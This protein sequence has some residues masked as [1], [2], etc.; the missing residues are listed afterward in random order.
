MPETWKVTILRRVIR[1]DAS[2]EGEIELLRFRIPY[3][4][5]DEDVVALGLFHNAVVAER[6]LDETEGLALADGWRAA[7]MDL[8][9]LVAVCAAFGI[10]YV[11][12]PTGPGL[13]DSYVGPV[14]VVAEKLAEAAGL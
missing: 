14:L 6:Y 13:A 9:D 4:E 2:Y 1:L 12:I 5:N 3:G 10:G 7:T 8:G 11:A